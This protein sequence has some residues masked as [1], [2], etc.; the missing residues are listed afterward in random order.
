MLDKLPS[1]Q[2]SSLFLSNRK[3]PGA[4]LQPPASASEMPMSSRRVDAITPNPFI[5]SG[6]GPYWKIPGVLSF[7]NN[8]PP[9]VIDTSDALICPN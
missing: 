5:D 1:V 7:T 6:C 3:L 2:L 4:Y 9:A 8:A